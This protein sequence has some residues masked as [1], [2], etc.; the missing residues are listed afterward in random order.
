[1]SVDLLAVNVGNTRCQLAAV[2]GDQ[3]HDVHTVARDREADVA[4]ALDQA[5]RP[6]ADHDQAPVYI[7]SVHDGAAD[8]L[9]RMVR[10]RCQREVRRVERDVAVPIG[11]QLDRETIVG[12]DRLLN[13]AAAY[14]R[15]QQACIVVDAGTAVT[16][17]L[18]DGAGTFHGGAILP[19]ARLQLQAMHSHTALLPD[20]ELARP[21][22]P[23]G[24]NTAQ[25]MLSGVFHGLRGSVRELAE[26]YAEHYGAYPKI[27]ATGGDANLLFE[28]YEL[29]EA[30]V[31]TLT[32]MGIMVTRRR[33]AEQA[34]S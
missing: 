5:L 13:A 1:M 10:A 32:L 18:V 7:A 25:A 4:A 20:I 2:V 11:R 34:D 31:P 19:G 12:V 6:L 24:H 17:D 22:E 8:D 29:V 16:V 26:I 14:D 15:L 3:L 21:D 33:E 30:V 9:T 27:I 28:D 23:I